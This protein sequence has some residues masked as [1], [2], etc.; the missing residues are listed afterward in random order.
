MTKFSMGDF[1]GKD[2]L[3]NIIIKIKHSGSN[4]DSIVAGIIKGI[5]HRDITYGYSNWSFRLNAV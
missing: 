2:E 5:F 3:Q 1:M 4:D